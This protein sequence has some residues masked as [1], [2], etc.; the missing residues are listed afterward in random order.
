MITQERLKEV[1]QYD[2]LAGHFTRLVRS[3]GGRKCRVGDI[4][5]RTKPGG[6]ISIK[7]DRKEYYAHRLAWLYV[8]GKFPDNEID[9]IN[10][11]PSDN[12]L[13]NL[14]DVERKENRKNQKI[15]NRNKSGIIGV[16][17]HQGIWRVRIGTDHI[18]HCLLTTDD[19]FEACCVRKSAEIKYGY[20]ANHGRT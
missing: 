6:Y 17:I 13:L 10:G 11:M 8:Y 15:S 1:L 7:I 5:G 20:H 12:R 2:P 9:H 18:S 4:A 3:S 19:F 14:R 16:D